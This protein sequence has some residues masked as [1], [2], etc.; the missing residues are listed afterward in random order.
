MDIDDDDIRVSPIRSAHGENSGLRILDQSNLV[1]SLSDLGI[2]K[3]SRK[4]FATALDSAYGV[5]IVSGPTGSGKTTTLYSA[6]HSINSLDKN[7]ITI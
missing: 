5:I 1:V 7:I 3:K 2:T 4:E 6:L